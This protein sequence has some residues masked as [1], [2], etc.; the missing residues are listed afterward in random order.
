M[1][2]GATDDR[3]VLRSKRM[4][5]ERDAA[6]KLSAAKPYP[7]IT[8]L[9]AVLTQARAKLEKYRE[10]HSGEYVGGVEYSVLIRRIDAAVAK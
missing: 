2:D 3:E 6:E 1:G 7:R 5:R 10:Q 4:I 8:E 9:E